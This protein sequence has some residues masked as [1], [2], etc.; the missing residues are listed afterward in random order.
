MFL[1][2]SL[3]TVKMHRFKYRFS[4]LSTWW[5]NI[6]IAITCNIKPEKSDEN[7][8]DDKYAEFDSVETINDLKAAIEHHGHSVVVLDADETIFEKLKSHKDDIDLVFNIAEGLKG[9][10]R[11]SIVQIYCEILEIPCHGPGPL[12]AAITLNKARTK[13]ILI[14]NDIPTPKSQV[15]YADDEQLN[16]SLSFPLL[17]KPSLEG[18]SKGI[19]NENLVDN[20]DDLKRILSK[21]MKNYKQSV[22]VEEFLTGREFT[23]AVISNHKLIVLPIVEITFDHLPEGIHHMES[24]EAKWIYDNPNA[25]DDPL[26]CPAKLSKELEEKIR[27]IAIK[28]FKALDC[29]DWTRIDMRLDNEDNPYVL[30]VNS[31]PGLMKNPKENSRL[32]RAAYAA[33]WT[34]EQLIGEV[35]ESAIIR[36]GL[37]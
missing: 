14:A 7:E 11:E 20:K 8:P 27:D 9:E 22:I 36:W 19:F 23:V 5:L 37:R 13:E 26:I 3:P 33:G 35:L 18:S 31:L 2:L 24:Y 6:N 15:F 21:I 12:T 25:T 32:P 10:F 30:E 4:R 28:T 1:L 34:Y 17:L 29:K 16:G